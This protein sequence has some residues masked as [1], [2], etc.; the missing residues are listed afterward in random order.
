[1]ATALKEAGAR[2]V[3]LAGK[4]EYEGVDANLYAGCDALDVIRTTFDDLGVAR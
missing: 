4:G 1:V 2:R 3:W